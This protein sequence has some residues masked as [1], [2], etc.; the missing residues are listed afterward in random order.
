MISRR[1][2]RGVT[3][4]RR[5]LVR[6]LLV[7]LGAVVSPGYFLA[8]GIGPWAI[9]PVV[10][11]GLLVGWLEYRVERGWDPGRVARVLDRPDRIVAV[12]VLSVVV[13]VVPPV[14]W[15]GVARWYLATLVGAGIGLL[16]NR[17]VYGLLRP[18]PGPY[19]ERVRTNRE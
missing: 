1:E 12:A 7:G 13:A 11:T 10:A 6:D 14:V 15:P 17:F 4:R 5:L 2:R 8:D 3:P 19:L 18:I 16:A 9:P